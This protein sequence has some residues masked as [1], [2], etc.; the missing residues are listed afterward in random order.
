[1]QAGVVVGDVVE[2]TAQDLVDPGAV[3]LGSIQGYHLGKV[4]KAKEADVSYHDVLLDLVSNIHRSTLLGRAA[5]LVQGRDDNQDVGCD[6]EIVVVGQFEELVQAEAVR[7]LAAHVW[8]EP[9]L[10]A[11]IRIFGQHNALLKQMLVEISGYD[12]ALQG[13]HDGESLRGR[14]WV[15]LQIGYE[16]SAEPD[17]ITAVRAGAER[18]E[19]LCDR[20]SLLSR[21]PD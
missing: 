12:S 11:P 9:R 21:P 18:W 1:M 19:F 15:R 2:V 10:V 6:S 13:F 17:G 14:P 16:P 3:E 7:K 8:D 4:C 5:E 20:G